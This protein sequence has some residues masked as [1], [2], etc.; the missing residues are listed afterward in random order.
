MY[1]YRMTELIIELS[2]SVEARTGIVATHPSE[3][4]YL[5]VS[6]FLKIG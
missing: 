5:V 4:I 2:Q 6:L 3:N 1:P